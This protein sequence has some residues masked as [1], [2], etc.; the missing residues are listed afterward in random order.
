[1]AENDDS[2]SR[3]NGSV[4]TLIEEAQKS[5]TSHF[6]L[7]PD[8][9]RL[10]RARSYPC[11]TELNY[12]ENRRK[13]HHLTQNGDTLMDI[14]KKYQKARY[15]HS[16]WRLVN[17]MRQL[18]ESVQHTTSEQKVIQQKQKV[19]QPETHV[20][21]HH[22]H[23]YHYSSDIPSIPAPNNTSFIQKWT[24]QTSITAKN[25]TT[26]LLQYVGIMPSGDKLT[27]QNNGH[28]P[29]KY[30]TMFLATMMMM[31]TFDPLSKPTMRGNKILRQWYQHPTLKR[32]FPIWLP[33]A[34]L[35]FY[36]VRCFRLK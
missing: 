8:P 27:P 26:S 16:Q 18:L 3:M 32:L 15:F 24:S 19:E 30:R 31:Q 33:K 34:H 35:V 9:I 7:K 13:S 36:L 21:I 25:A 22:H 14:R 17:T 20:H 6:S 4:E 1:M 29:V 10:R 12:P 5:L 28:P 23:H 11:F 2:L